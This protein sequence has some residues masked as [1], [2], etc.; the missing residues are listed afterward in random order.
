MWMLEMVHARFLME[1]TLQARQRNVGLESALCHFW[2]RVSRPI[3]GGVRVFEGQLSQTVVADFLGFSR[4]EVNRKMKLLES[5]GFLERQPNKV[6]LH[7]ESVAQVL[8]T[9]WL[10]MKLPSRDKLPAMLSGVLQRS[11]AVKACTDA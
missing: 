11:E 3:P 5:T 2:W 4:E 7:I 1:Q 8:D 6:V 9:S 10:N